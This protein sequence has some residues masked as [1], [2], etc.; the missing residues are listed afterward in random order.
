MVAAD[1]VPLHDPG[2]AGVQN[3][4]E[5]AVNGDAGWEL[6]AGGDDLATLQSIAVDLERR[7]GVAPCVDC[8]QD[9]VPRVV[10]ERALR[11]EAIGLGSWCG[12]A[13]EAA[14]R[15]DAC[16][17]QRAVG[18]TVVDDDA[19]SGE[20]VR[21]GPDDRAGVPVPVTMPLS[22]PVPVSAVRI[23]GLCARQSCDHRDEHEECCMYHA[24]SSLDRM[25]T[26]RKCSL[27]GS[28]YAV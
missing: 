15:V 27:L 2:A 7:H 23:G 4:D 24:C 22:V 3:V 6:A 14:R 8:D 18:R 25:S 19:V 26:S 11:R 21:L 10:D 13:A 16:L 5:T 17:R 28:S 20:L 9:R 12:S 1:L